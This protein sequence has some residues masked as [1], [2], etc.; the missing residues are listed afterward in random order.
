[1][2]IASVLDEG[3]GSSSVYD[4]AR[5]ASGVAR[6]LIAI[7]VRCVIAAGWAVDDVAAK[8]FASTFYARLLAGERFID[9]VAE[10]RSVAYDYDS[11]TWAAYQCYGD[12]DWRIRRDGA[13]TSAEP[14][15]HEF[16]GVTSVATLKLALETLLVQKTYQGHASA[17]MLK[18]VR[19]L[20]SAGAMRRG[21]PP[22][23]W[24]SSLRAFTPRWEIST[25]AIAWYDRAIG[26]ADGSVSMRALEQRANLLVRRA[27]STLE[28]ARPRAGATGDTGATGKKGRRSAAPAIAPDSALKAARAT[29]EEEWR[30]SAGSW[31]SVP[32]RSRPISV[33]RR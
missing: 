9:A 20:E 13:E 26:V 5:F 16:E 4:R 1:M 28:A 11:S 2:P 3:R 31:N 12:P 25:T 19:M 15:E 30:S 33:G 18:R 21:A 27:W 7:G 10:A 17:E 8:A 29:I 22:T 24:P 6:E 14:S 23:A 32:L